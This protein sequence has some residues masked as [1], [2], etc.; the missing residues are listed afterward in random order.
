[1]S[2]WICRAEGIWNILSQYIHLWCFWCFSMCILSYTY[3][4]T[5]F[6]TVDI[7]VFVFFQ[8]PLHNNM[9][10]LK[11][12]AFCESLE[13]SFSFPWILWNKFKNRALLDCYIIS[14]FILFFH[15]QIVFPSSA[16]LIATST[17]AAAILG[18]SMIVSNF[19]IFIFIWLLH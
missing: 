2:S 18:N 16:V 10:F 15:I 1:M 7:Y 3:K 9:C 8:R 5:H 6:Y 11:N 4:D 13:T 19:L 12:L 17:T 14:P